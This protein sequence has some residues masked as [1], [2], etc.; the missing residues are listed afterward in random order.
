[1]KLNLLSSIEVGNV[2]DTSENR[3]LF[4]KVEEEVKKGI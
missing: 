2:H 4:M 3:R 1:M